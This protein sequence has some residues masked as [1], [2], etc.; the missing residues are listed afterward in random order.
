MTNPTNGVLDIRTTGQD[1]FIINLKNVSGTNI[2]GFY[3][4]NNRSIVIKRF[5]W[6][7]FKNKFRFWWCLILIGG[8]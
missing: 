6:Y 2:G 5:Q 3:T 7:S 1:R 4:T 8:N